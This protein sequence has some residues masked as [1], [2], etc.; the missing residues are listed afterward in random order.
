MYDFS[1]VIDRRGTGSVK[2][3]VS[4]P[5]GTDEKLT[6]FWIADMD[7][8]TLP[9]VTEALRTRIGHPIFGYSI[10]PAGAIESVCGWYAR[11]HG[12]SFS[13]DEVICGIGVVTM[14]RYILD[15]LTEPGDPVIVM[16]PVYDAFFAVVKNAGR[17]CVDVPLISGPDGYRMDLDGVASALRAGARTILFCNPHNPVGRVWSGEELAALSALCGE[18]GAW[19]ISDEVHGDIE[20]MGSRYHPMGTIEGARGRCIVCTAIS[21]TF[22]LAGLQQ[23]CIVIQNPEMYK[24]V[25]DALRG[26][27]IMGPNVLA[28][29][30]MRAAYTHGDRWVDELNAYI[31]ENARYVAETLS[32]RAPEIKTY[33]PE[34]GYLMWLDL[35]RLGKTSGELSRLLVERSRVAVGNG[36]NYGPEAD[37]FMRLNIGCPRETLRVAVEA[38]ADLTYCCLR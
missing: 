37:G 14:I 16:S 38:L 5:F 2:W 33:I 29:Y 20:L 30:A 32:E 26:A 11:R 21:K 25:A 9:E 19:I 18:Y 28:Y 17:S 34:G 8:P 6:P 1:E 27:W 31:G 7:F 23:S 36:K 10:P 35:R 15:V 3:D 22:N 24:K 4:E 12:Y 13:P